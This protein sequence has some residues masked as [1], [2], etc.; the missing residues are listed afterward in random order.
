VMDR[1]LADRA[2]L[3][4]A[5]PIADIAC[6]PWVV[7]HETHKQ[8]IHDFPHLKRWFDAIAARPATKRAYVLAPASRPPMSEEE[9]KILFGQGARLP[10]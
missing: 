2:Y 9:R 5:Y 6:Y 4:G 8:N 3:A 10:A 7:P 1:R